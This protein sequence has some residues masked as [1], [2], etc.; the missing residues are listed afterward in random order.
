MLTWWVVAVTTSGHQPAADLAAGRVKPGKVNEKVFARYLDEPEIPE[1]DLF[2]RS[3]GERRFS[4]FLL[5]QSACAEM[6][7]L[8]RLWPDFDAGTCGKE[9]IPGYAAAWVT[10]P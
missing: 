9:T 2:V 4:D 7:F 6:V 3:S 1:V 5:W 8:A 10:R